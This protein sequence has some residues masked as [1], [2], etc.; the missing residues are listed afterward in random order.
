MKDIKERL[1][2]VIELEVF[3]VNRATELLKTFEK[4]YTSA[5]IAIDY[6]E[7]CIT[8]KF[9]EITRHG[10]PDSDWI[11]LTI[12]ELEMGNE[13]WYNHLRKRMMLTML[14]CNQS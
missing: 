5:V 2:Q 7:N 6:E 9:Q 13:D 11:I 8:V 14:S 3:A 10:S 4:P 12:D 1:K